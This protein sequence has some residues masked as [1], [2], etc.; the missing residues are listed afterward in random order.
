MEVLKKREWA[1][2]AVTEM[3][4]IITYVLQ[5]RR[6]W[7]VQYL[8][9]KLRWRFRK[10]LRFES[11]ITIEIL[12]I[13]ITRWKFQYKVLWLNWRTFFITR[14]EE[15]DEENEFISNFM[16]T[17][18][19]KQQKKC[20]NLSGKEWKRLLVVNVRVA[21][22]IQF[23]PRVHELN[24]NRNRENVSVIQHRDAISAVERDRSLAG[25]NL[26]LENSKTRTSW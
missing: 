25:N 26:V 3:K 11:L 10:S 8:I 18:R 17:I 4:I 19:V 9:I 1:C 22:K 12:T 5:S 7:S 13:L 15:N 21:W 16:I 23:R 24:C 6:L 14:W 20:V 2:E